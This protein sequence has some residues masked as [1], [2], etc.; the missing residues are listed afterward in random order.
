MGSEVGTEGGKRE[1]NALVPVGVA[2]DY[3]LWKAGRA[4]SHKVAPAEGERP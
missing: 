1:Q 3:L 4:V 2:E